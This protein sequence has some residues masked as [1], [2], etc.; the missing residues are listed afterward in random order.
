MSLEKVEKAI[1]VLSNNYTFFEAPLIDQESF[2]AW[3]EQSEQ[4]EEII[5]LSK[6]IREALEEDWARLF[7]KYCDALIGKP[8]PLTEF[9]CLKYGSQSLLRTLL[10]LNLS[11]TNVIVTNADHPAIKQWDADHQT[12][13]LNRKKIAAM[14]E[15]KEYMSLVDS[16]GKISK[17]ADNLYARGF[18]NEG[19]HARRLADDISREFKQFIDDPSADKL[20]QFKRKAV[21]R[22]D[23]ARPILEQHRGWKRFLG[24]LSLA[25]ITFGIG[26]LPAISINKLI[27]G[28]WLFFN[29]TDSEEKI[30]KLS[31][32]I[33]KMAFVNS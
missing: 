30:D 20:I 13:V 33:D 27:T 7:P 12:L 25:I 5:A 18:A 19:A 24:N 3:L 6:Q 31:I 17:K 9:Y 15:T 23:K 29:K 8:L 28:H 14:F 16:L 10:K 32:A 4:K 22:I 11:L 26:Y 2:K 21:S 1:E